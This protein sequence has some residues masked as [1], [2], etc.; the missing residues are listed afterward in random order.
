MSTPAD[1]W[2]NTV[3]GLRSSPVLKQETVGR[4]AGRG[5]KGT[6]ILYSSRSTDTCVKKRLKVLIQ[7]V[8]HVK[9]KKETVL[10]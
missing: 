6:H 3:R 1:R 5:A 2:V 8:T 4:P 7:L 10:K 9:S